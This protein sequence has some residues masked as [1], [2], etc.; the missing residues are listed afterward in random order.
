MRQTH[1]TKEIERKPSAN[2]EMKFGTR[3]AITDRIFDE[4]KIVVKPGA[5]I[6][7]TDATRDA[8]TGVIPV[9]G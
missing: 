3:A 5:I 6:V 7:K 1:K 4:E 8:I 9:A 2:T